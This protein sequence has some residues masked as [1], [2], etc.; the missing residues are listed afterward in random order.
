MDGHS[1]D[2][3]T[4]ARFFGAITIRLVWS[5]VAFFPS[6]SFRDDCDGWLVVMSAVLFPR[7]HIVQDFGELVVLTT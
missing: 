7:M 2:I 1:G 4:T 6:N 3:S 5:G